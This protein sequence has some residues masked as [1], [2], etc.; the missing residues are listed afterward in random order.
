MA[1]EGTFNAQTDLHGDPYLPG[2]GVK[3]AQ[4]FA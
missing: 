4:L 1:R 3:V 2:F